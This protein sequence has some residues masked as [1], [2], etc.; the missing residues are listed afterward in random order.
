M[1][2]FGFKSEKGCGEGN[3]HHML[4]AGL[5]TQEDCTRNYQQQWFLLGNE[6]GNVLE[7]EEDISLYSLYLCHIFFTMCLFYFL[8]QFVKLEKRKTK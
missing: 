1:L 8:K 6:Q 3:R 5:S 4:V 2:S 7:W